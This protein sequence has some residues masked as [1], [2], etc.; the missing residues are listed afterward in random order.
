MGLPQRTSMRI[1]IFLLL[2]ASSAHGQTYRVQTPPPVRSTWGVPTPRR[3]VTPFAPQA[4]RREIVIPP[5]LHV[6]RSPGLWTRSQ[7]SIGSATPTPAPTTVPHRPWS[8]EQVWLEMQ[9]RRAMEARN[10]GRPVNTNNNEPW[11]TTGP[12]NARIINQARLMRR[13]VSGLESEGAEGL[14]GLLADIRGAP[15]PTSDGPIRACPG[16]ITCR[17]IRI[18]RWSNQNTDGVVGFCRSGASCNSGNPQVQIITTHRGSG[19]VQSRNTYLHGTG[20]LLTGEQ[21]TRDGN[22]PDSARFSLREMNDYLAR[23]AGLNHNAR[24]A[25]GGAQRDSTR[26]MRQDEAN[27]AAGIYDPKMP[28]QTVVKEDK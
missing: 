6:V 24:S 2:L 28:T 5:N 27:R 7:D 15:R 8:Q 18:E 23:R 17:N 26:R 25:I 1:L 19:G 10:Y 16:G 21:Q 14:G 13:N 11:Q 22:P 4:Q 3:V 12:A 20:Y 9:A